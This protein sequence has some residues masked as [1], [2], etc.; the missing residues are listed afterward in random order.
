MR[1]RSKIVA[2][3]LWLFCLWLI[4]RATHALGLD[5]LAMMACQAAVATFA[6][7]DPLV[8]ELESRMMERR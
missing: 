1:L 6:E 3:T 8:D 7:I 5:W 4:A 2:W